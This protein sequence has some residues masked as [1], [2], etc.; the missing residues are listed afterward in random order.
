M[1]RGVLIG[2]R[3]FFVLGLGALG[4][5]F[6]LAPHRDPAESGASSS[7]VAGP[8]APA[9]AEKA[10]RGLDLSGVAEALLHYRLGEIDAGDAAVRSADT[11]VR[12]ALEWDLLRQRL[13]EAGLPRVAA[14]LRG[15]ADWPL[16]GLRRRAEDLAAADSAQADQA[17]AY[18]SEFP[19]LTPNGQAAWAS[20]LKDPARAVEAE[21]LARKLWREADLT[22]AL[23]DRLSKTFGAVLT[24]EDHLR[25][26][27][28]LVMRGQLEG[29]SRVASLAGKEAAAL[30]RVEAD[31]MNGA[32]FAQV[33]ARVPEKLASAPGLLFARSRAARKAGRIDEAAKLLLAAPRAAEG[34]APDEFSVERRAVARKLLES[35]DAIS[36]YALSAGHLAVSDEA[37]QESEFLA[38]W[39]ALRFLSDPVRAAP[40]FDRLAEISHSPQAR[41][42]AAWWR[43]RAAEAQAAATTE[44][45][46]VEAAEHSESFYGQLA[47]AR[48]GRPATELRPAPPAAEG[49]ARAAPVRAAELLFALGQKDAA[50]ALTL[51]AAQDLPPDQLAALGRVAAAQGDAHIALLT[52]KAA[53]RRGVA[54]D[55]LGW[56]LD[57]VP[58]FAPLPHS[59]PRPVALAI[60]RQ[61]SAFDPAA[62]SSAGALGL[63]QMMPSTA[64]STA[65]QAGLA[66][67]EARLTGDPVY[68]AQLGAFHLG[69]LLD[70]FNGAHILAFAAYNAGRG[71]VRAWIAAFGD[72]RDP[73]VDPIDWIERIPFSETRN[74]VQ[75][76]AENL[77]LYRLRLGDPTPDLFTSDLRQRI[78]AQ[79][80]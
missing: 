64:R 40:H 10:P 18:F 38:G 16:N 76:V 30:A 22:P 8:P 2:G 42:R 45:F 75:R 72:P 67:D 48:L 43:G 55:E 54:L 3:L 61:E 63:M 14:F 35:G 31:L 47:R 24:L 39:I 21:A 50:L 34:I 65:R 23:E 13:A 25:R 32:S 1:Q 4:A 36:A 12:A 74:Y 15:H 59:A 44:A 33:S 11:L 17:L 49:A 79:A 51:E 78:A 7:E 69:Q 26:L 57:G 27:D 20:L 6:A 28:R 56:P 60:A 19:P 77:H 73:K 9:A 62:R 5:I 66:F 52:A 71:N 70:E 41:A 58:D 53:L 37:R 46:F 29:A 68:N 80:P